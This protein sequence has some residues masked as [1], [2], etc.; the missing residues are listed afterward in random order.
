MTIDTNG[1]AGPAR[2]PSSAAA[3]PIEDLWALTPEQRAEALYAGRLSQRQCF[4]WA[5]RETETL[6]RLNGEYWFIA[7]TT[8]EIAD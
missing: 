6:P 5:R 4:E 8:P 1:A 7:I 2:E 3:G